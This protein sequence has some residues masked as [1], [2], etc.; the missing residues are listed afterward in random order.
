MTGAARRRPERIG[1]GFCPR[2][3]R[4][5]AGSSRLARLASA[6]TGQRAWIE[7]RATQIRCPAP[8]LALGCMSFGQVFHV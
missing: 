6:W 2:G 8:L 7:A 4:A 3:K 5:P 1:E